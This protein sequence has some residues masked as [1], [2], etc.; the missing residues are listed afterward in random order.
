MERTPRYHLVQPPPLKVEVTEL[1][2]NL[3]KITQRMRDITRT[4]ARSTLVLG[5]LY[6]YYRDFVQQLYRESVT[7]SSESQGPATNCTGWS[8]TYGNG[9]SS[10]RN[11]P[12]SL[13]R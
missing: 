13:R 10:P 8:S 7:L 6:L 9:L 12:W 4:R 3:S 11:S 1:V 5:L 2:T